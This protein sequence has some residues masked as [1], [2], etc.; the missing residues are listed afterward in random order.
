MTTPEAKLRFKERAIAAL[1]TCR[2]IKK[3]AEEADVSERTMLRWMKDPAFREEYERAKRDLLSGAINRLRLGSFDAAMR[4]HRT[5]L[6]RNAPVGV[7]VSAAGRLL[8]LLREFA[9]DEDLSSRVDRL[10]ELL[11]GD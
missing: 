6:D 3:A 2:T 10:E 1:L 9:R 7:S 11:K 4:L 5:V 8:D